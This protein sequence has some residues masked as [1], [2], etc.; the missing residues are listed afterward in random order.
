L[1]AESHPDAVAHVT[2]QGLPALPGYCFDPTGQPAHGEFQTRYCYVSQSTSRPDID[3]LTEPRQSGM[4]FAQV[5]MRPSVQHLITSTTIVQQLLAP[6]LRQFNCR[7]LVSLGELAIDFPMDST[8]HARLVREVYA[9]YTRA[10]RWYEITLYLTTQ[11][12]IVRV[13]LYPKHEHGLALLRV[14][15]VL[16]RRFWRR[17]GINEPEDLRTTSSWLASAGRALQFVEYRATPRRSAAENA[18]IEELIREYGV[19]EALRRND[20]GDRQRIRRRLVPTDTDRR[21]REALEQFHRRLSRRPAS[22]ETSSNGR[23]G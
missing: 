6:F 19:N 14:E 8:T 17:H 2:P 4:P 22:A 7:P 12:G 21:A 13:R 18:R 16:Q 23:A 10:Q 1:H 5:S 9:P 11:S 20:G 3:L 15:Q